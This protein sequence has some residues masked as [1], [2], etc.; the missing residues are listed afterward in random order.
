MLSVLTTDILTHSLSHIHTHANG[1]NKG[2]MR[3]LWKVVNVFVAL[4]V[5]MVS[6]V[7]L[8]PKSIELY[9]L[10]M[11]SFLHISHTSIKWLKNSN[12]HLNVRH[13]S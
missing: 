1:N 11:Y 12:T 4:R 13:G 5:V 2:V 10:Y 3:T 8:I 9:K 6:Q 7:Y